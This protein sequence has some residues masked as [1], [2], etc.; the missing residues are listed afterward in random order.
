MSDNPK[1]SFELKEFLVGMEKRILDDSKERHEKHEDVTN[2][3]V[4][5]LYW[6]IGILVTVQIAITGLLFLTTNG[7]L[8]RLQSQVNQIQSAIYQLVGNPNSGD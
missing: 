1:I 5:K 7:S 4:G 8:D 2:R 6:F 3:T